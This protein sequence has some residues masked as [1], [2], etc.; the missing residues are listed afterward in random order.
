MEPSSGAKNFQFISIFLCFDFLILTEPNFHSPPPNIQ[1]PVFTLKS[2]FQSRTYAKFCIAIRKLPLEHKAEQLR[3]I[4][5]YLRNERL[6]LPDNFQV[7]LSLSC[8][9]FYQTLSIFYQIFRYGFHFHFP[10]FIK[11]CQSNER[12]GRKFPRR[13]S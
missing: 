11:L 7:W 8:D 12:I 13:Q 4:L 6:L 9:N 3:Y 1:V 2:K 10:I 5:D